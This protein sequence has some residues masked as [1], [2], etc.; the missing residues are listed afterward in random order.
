MTKSAKSRNMARYRVV[1]AMGQNPM[2]RYMM[3]TLT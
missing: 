2:H 3:A 1:T